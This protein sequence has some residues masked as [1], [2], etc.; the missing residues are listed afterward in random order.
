MPAGQP[1]LVESSKPALEI[2][3]VSA[4]MFIEFNSK[5]I[6]SMLNLDLIFIISYSF[7]NVFGSLDNM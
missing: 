7:F 4:Y 5:K 1:E 2:R 6:A 3:F